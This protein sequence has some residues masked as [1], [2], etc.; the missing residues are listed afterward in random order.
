MK[1]AVIQSNG[2]LD[3]LTATAKNRVTEGI[4]KSGGQIDEIHLNKLKIEQCQACGNGQGSCLKNGMYWKKDN[5]SEIYE[6]LI[7]LDGIVIISAVY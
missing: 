3:E 7:D 6:K 2:N 5:F 1:V 4:K